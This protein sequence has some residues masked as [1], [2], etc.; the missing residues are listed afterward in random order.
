MTEEQN[1][2]QRL[3]IEALEI[4]RLARD[5]AAASRV[6]AAGASNDVGEVKAELK[7]HTRVL[8][9]LRETQVEHG[10]RLDR[11]ET[12]MRNGFAMMAQ[13]MARITELI[14]SRES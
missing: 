1:E 4:A 7:A 3:A 6:L 13:G 9:A 10:Q 2:T 14:E 8:N 12:E 5:E 11:V